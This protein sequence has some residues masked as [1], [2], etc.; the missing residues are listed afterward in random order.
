L[1]LTAVE[2]IEAKSSF[3]KKRS[4]KLCDLASACPDKLSPGSQKS[5]GSFLQKRTASFHPGFSN[6]RA[7]P[8]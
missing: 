1:C 5:S 7:I 4:K 8:M 6:D 3:L 2:I